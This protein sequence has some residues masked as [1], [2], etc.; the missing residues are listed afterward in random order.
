MQRLR[1]LKRNP[2]VLL[3]YFFNA[4]FFQFSHHV[5]KLFKVQAQI[6]ELK[7]SDRHGFKFLKGSLS[8]RGSQL[9]KLVNP[10]G[11]FISGG[12]NT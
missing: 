4:E 10:N 6:L 3:R 11:S 5:P 7:G 8:L 1:L 12:C 2:G 9:F